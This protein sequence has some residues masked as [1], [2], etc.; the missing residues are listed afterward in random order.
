MNNLTITPMDVAAA[1]EVTGWR[2]PPPYDFYN[3]DES[4]EMLVAIFSDPIYGY[5]QLRE[6][7]ALVGF[8]CCGEEGQVR[9]GDYSVPALDV[10]IAMRPDLTGRGMGR[11][12]MGAVLTFAEQ[13]FQPPALRLTVAAFNGRARQLYTSL[14]FQ[15]NQRFTSAASMREYIVMLRLIGH[16]YGGTWGHAEDST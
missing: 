9:G 3:L 7:T 8:C 5:F 10:G 2:Y 16:E 11:Y 15:I 1:R 12:Y 13:H 6:P 4:T 14:G